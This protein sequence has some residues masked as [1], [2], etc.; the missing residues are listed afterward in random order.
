L[1]RLLHESAEHET[2]RYSLVPRYSLALWAGNSIGMT[3]QSFH[4]RSSE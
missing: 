3:G 1:I 2:E 4:R